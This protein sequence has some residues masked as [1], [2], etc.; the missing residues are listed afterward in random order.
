MP[1]TR[2]CPGLDPGP[3]MTELE[4]NNVGS[5]AAANVELTIDFLVQFLDRPVRRRSLL[6]VSDRR[7]RVFATGCR[8]LPRSRE[9]RRSRGGAGSGAALRRCRLAAGRNGPECSGIGRGRIGG[10]CRCHRGGSGR[11]G[12][13]SRINRLGSEFGRVRGTCRQR[14]GDG[15]GGL[16]RQDQNRRMIVR[17]EQNPRQDRRQDDAET[18]QQAVRSLLS[19]RSAHRANEKPSPKC[20]ARFTSLSG[21]LVRRSLYNNYFTETRGRKWE[22][23]A[24]APGVAAA[25]YPRNSTMSNIAS[26]ESGSS[27]GGGGSS[28]TTSSSFRSVPLRRR[29]AA[30]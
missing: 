6:F 10:D 21:A 24:E 13:R 5:A 16:P 27:P 26:L 8:L 17:P 7:F 29:S 3:G 18:D 4:E 28:L 2:A 12:V 14:S 20:A 11:P 25:S 23:C 19:H 30:L 15:N 9:R 1:G 22:V